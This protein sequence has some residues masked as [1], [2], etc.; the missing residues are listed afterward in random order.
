MKS[1]INPFSHLHLQPFQIQENGADQQAIAFIQANDTDRSGGLNPKELIDAGGL[2]GQQ[3]GMTPQEMERL[4]LLF[5]SIAGSDE[6]SAMELTQA[7][8]VMDN[9]IKGNPQMGQAINYNNLFQFGEG[10]G[11]HGKLAPSAIEKQDGVQYNVVAGE[12]KKST[13]QLMIEHDEI[14]SRL[15]AIVENMN[16]DGAGLSNFNPGGGAAM[17]PDPGGQVSVLGQKLGI[18]L[19]QTAIKQAQKPGEMGGLLPISPGEGF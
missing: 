6:L 9:T 10:A 19:E 1:N 17:G 16:D 18:M 8:L 4:K 3:Q 11:V 12:D 15:M 5:P 14:L 2:L 7:R 13:A